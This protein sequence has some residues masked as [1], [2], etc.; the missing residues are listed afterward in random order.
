MKYSPV[1][2]PETL[3]RTTTVLDWTVSR[4]AFEYGTS[5]IRTRIAALLTETFSK[6]K[7]YY[8]LPK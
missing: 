2:Y 4:L 6:M 8:H 5:L 1:I 3:K 7:Q